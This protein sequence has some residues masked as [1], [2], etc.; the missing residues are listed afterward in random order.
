MVLLF[1]MLDCQ[2]HSWN[3]S[4]MA[5]QLEIKFLIKSMFAPS[6]EVVGEEKS[7]SAKQNNKQTNKQTN[8]WA[9]KSPT[10]L[11]STMCPWV[12]EDVFGL[13]VISPWAR[14]RNPHPLGGILGTYIVLKYSP[15]VFQIRLFALLKW[16]R[17]AVRPHSLCE[18]KKTTGYPRRGFWKLHQKCPDKT[19][20]TI[21]CV[22][23]SIKITYMILSK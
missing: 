15:R 14:R 9:K 18:A 1:T 3:G 22:C 10:F 4:R 8:K 5:S 19:H 20:N 16:R 23:I 7:E 6:S 13:S 11:L 21:K 12:F 2:K 17:L